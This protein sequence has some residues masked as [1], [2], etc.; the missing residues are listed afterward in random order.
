MAFRELF[1]GEGK[2]MGLLSV[3]VSLEGVHK[4]MD[5]VQPTLSVLLILVQLAVAGITLRHLILKMLG[6]R[7]DK[8]ETESNEEAES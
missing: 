8:K 1:Q 6:R 7:R 4:L 3:N 2:L 5:A